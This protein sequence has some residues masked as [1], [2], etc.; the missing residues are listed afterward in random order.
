MEVSASILNVRKE[1]VVGAD[2]LIKLAGGAR[3]WAYPEESV[4]LWMLVK[5]EGQTGYASAR[6]LEEVETP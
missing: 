3:V 1:A 5:V 2:V 6:F 4:G